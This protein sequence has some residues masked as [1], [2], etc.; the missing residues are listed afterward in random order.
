[1]QKILKN[2]IIELVTRYKMRRILRNA[3]LL[4]NAA[5][6]MGFHHIFV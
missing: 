3:S 4:Q 6:H 2:G 5:E 1:M